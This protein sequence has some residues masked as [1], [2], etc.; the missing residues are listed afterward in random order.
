MIKAFILGYQPT[1]V[2]F[3]VVFFLADSSNTFTGNYEIPVAVPSITDTDATIEANIV[4]DITAFCST[5]G[6]TVPSSF[7]W[8]VTSPSDVATAIAAAIAALPSALPMLVSGVAKA[9]TYPIVGA[10]SVAG[11]AG[12]ARFFID[13]N[14]DGTGTAPSAVFA[15]S[16]Q[17]VVV[18]ASNVYIPSSVTVDTNR[19]YI[20]V[21]L[22]E[23]TFASTI[24]SLI[25]VLTGASLG[26]A[27]NATVVNCFVLVQK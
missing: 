16:L 26:A 23:L 9:N 8:T 10:P 12:V 1:G 3:S 4:A 25:N 18:N 20:D 27:P 17:A 15:S 19:K 7:D 14:G 2:N 22:K 21:G 5:N 11:G 24:L 6:I 13:S